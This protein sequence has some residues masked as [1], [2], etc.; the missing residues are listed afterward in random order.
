M[1]TSPKSP[2]TADRVTPHVAGEAT[3]PAVDRPARRP[4]RKPLPRPCGQI[5]PSLLG[6][7]PDPPQSS[8]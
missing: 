1:R 3:E 7:P 2:S 6:S 5:Q 8:F 4:Y